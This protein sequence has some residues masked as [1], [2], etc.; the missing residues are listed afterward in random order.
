MGGFVQFGLELIDKLPLSW[1]N[2]ILSRALY[3]FIDRY[4]KV[5]AINVENVKE[6]HGKSTIY[7]GNHL[8][9]V[10]GPILYR[11]LGP[12][13]A[14]IAGVKLQDVMLTNKILQIYDFIE[15]NPGTPD[16]TAVKKAV[17]HLKDG[18]SVL[19]FPEGTR[20]RSG[21]MQHALK[22][23]TLL[24]RLANVPILPI[25]LAG[26]E[27]LFPIDDSDMG[28]ERMQ[29]ADVRIEFGKAFNVPGRD[30]YDGDDYSTYA[31]DYCM[32]E[33]AKL[34]PEEY[35]GVYAEDVKDK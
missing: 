21:T 19:I 8:S 26:T 14:F 34:L 11:F 2:S 25:G 28:S 30:N 17:K 31:A 15:I 1:Q 18:G 13:V 22:G 33:V 5:E 23:F 35:R 3:F 29:K 27:K 7:I 6:R 24:A 20:S 10:D 32:I 16:L 4:A 12:K 9:N